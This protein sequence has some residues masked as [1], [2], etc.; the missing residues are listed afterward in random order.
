[1]GFLDWFSGATPAGI[2]SEASS[3]TVGSLFTGIKDI[4]KEFHLSPEDELKL[5]LAVEQQRLEF[6][7]AQTSDVQNAR[8]MQMVTK[9]VWPGLLSALMLI[10]FFSGGSYILLH[11]IPAADADGRII[12]MLF[13]QTLISG[14]TLVLGYWL[15]S[16]SGSQAKD[17]MLFHSMPAEKK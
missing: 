1:M 7:K 6:Y 8:S 3:A 16:S 5:N 17:S 11:G 13:A 9:S 10:G 2:V 15:G 12:L 4:I 14:V